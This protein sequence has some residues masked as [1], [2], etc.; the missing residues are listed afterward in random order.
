[1]TYEERTNI[2]S[3][4]ENLNNLVELKKA[5][6]RSLDRVEGDIEFSMFQ[7]EEQTDD[8]TFASKP[9]NPLRSYQDIMQGVIEDL[10]PC[11][12]VAIK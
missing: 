11:W 4:L 3:Y 5:L 7:I 8:D 1:M 12:K 2:E 10:L 9:L 6:K